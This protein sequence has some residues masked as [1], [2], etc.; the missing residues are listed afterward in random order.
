M[1]NPYIIGITGGSASGKTVFLNSLME[2]FG[3]DDI[4]LISQ[5]NYYKPRETQPKDENGVINFDTTESIDYLSFAKDIADLKSGKVVSKKEY[6]FN[7]PNVVPKDLIFKPAPI[8]VVEGL[9]VF[10]FPE[11]ASQ[12]NLKVFIDSHL[13]LMLKRRII[14]DA[15]ER[16]YD[17]NDVLYRFEKH[18]VPAYHT[19]IEPLRHSA[20]II[21]P[22]NSDFRKGLAVL[23]AHL[24]V[25]LD[26]YRVHE[27]D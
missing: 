23:S 1:N 12:L 5:D 8:I 4:C 10:Y 22:N 13:Y 7:N 14:R 25:I 27:K 21:V 15:T 2:A 26:D 3:Q 9:F 11:I 18:V 19:Y 16:G 17:L 24:K 20:D 6:T